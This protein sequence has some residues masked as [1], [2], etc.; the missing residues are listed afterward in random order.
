MAQTE[1]RHSLMLF[2]V[3]Y[4]GQSTPSLVLQL[5][6]TWARIQT[7]PGTSFQQLTP[8]ATVDSRGTRRFLL[9]M[10]RVNG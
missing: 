6:A 2:L 3:G 1:I 8:M 4:V 10:L 9:R 5:L 7:G